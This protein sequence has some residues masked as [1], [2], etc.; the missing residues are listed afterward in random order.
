MTTRRA[1][2]LG[3]LAL[4]GLAIAPGLARAQ[5]QQPIVLPSPRADFGKSLAQALKLRRSM[6][7]FAPRPLPPQVLSELLWCA[8]GVNRPATADRTAPSWRHAR[9]TEVFA[10]MADGVWRYDAIGHRLEPVIAADVRAQT[11]V[12]DFVGSAPLDLVYVSNAEH[13][14]GVSREEQRRVASAD[15]GFIGQNVYLYCASEGL[16]C[17]FRASLDAERLARTLR[18]NETQF[19]MFSQTVGYPRM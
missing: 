16:A 4:A 3:I 2:N 13:L 7:E 18:L 19:V 1:T 12:Q 11:G 5:A 10:V 8:Y 14:S 6:R 15:T 17:V 9:E